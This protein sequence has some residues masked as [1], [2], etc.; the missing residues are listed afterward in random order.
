[1]PY[2][3]LVAAVEAATRFLQHYVEGG[4][5]YTTQDVRT[6]A[7]RLW[8]LCQQLKKADYPD[9]PRSKRCPSPSARPET[10]WSACD[11]G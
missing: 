8:A 6:G 9:G 5:G 3:Q 4:R 1:M 7:T 2:Q 10:A 11:G